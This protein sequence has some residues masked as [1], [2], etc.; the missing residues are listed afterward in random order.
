MTF[1]RLPTLMAAVALCIVPA[2]CGSD[3]DSS[4]SGS[5]TESSETAAITFE[6]TEP[7]KGK[8]AIAGP[9]TVEAGV[10]EITLENGTKNPHDA[11][12]LR[13]EGDRSADEVISNSVDSEEGAPI[14]DWLTDGGGLGRVAP[15]KSATA[16]QVLTPGTYYLL[17]SESAQG[18]ETVN[19][20]RG[21]VAKFEVTGEEVA[22]ATLPATDATITAKDFSFETAGIVPGSNRLTF[23][24]TGEQLHHVI[25]LPII[26]GSTIADVEEFA[27]GEQTNGPPPV[28]FE[29]AQNTAVID[30]GQ[31][32]VIDME[33]DKGKYALVCFITNR[34]G[35]PAHAVM[36]MVDELDV[37]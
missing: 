27:S 13:V 11:Q 6:T 30:G 19:A 26:E 5:T 10:V 23:E 17:D 16:T 9:D 8:V 24:N 25:A 32:Q 33:F 15:G 1:R 4:D 34:D 18:S 22:D 31:A 12:I 14:P 37:K 35:G 29:S 20:R 2:A 7:A 28:D 36:G 3:D 21:G